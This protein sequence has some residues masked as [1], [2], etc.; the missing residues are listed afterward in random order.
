MLPPH[1]S[2]RSSIQGTTMSQRKE[3]TGRDAFIIVEALTFA[4]EA[5]SRLPIEF[6]PDNNINDMKRLID[7]AVKQDRTLAQAQL[8]AHRRLRM[9]LAHKEG[10]RVFDLLWVGSA[11]CVGT[12]QCMYN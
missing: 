7:E 6:R 3:V 8:I 2:P 11:N 4:V 1:Q 9:L 12:F 10:G 5:L